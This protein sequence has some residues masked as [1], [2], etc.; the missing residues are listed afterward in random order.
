MFI[1]ETHSTNDL[2]KKMSTTE[3]LEEYYT[4]R[5]DYQSAGKGQQGAKWESEKGKNLLVSIL[6]YPNELEKK[7]P[8]RLTQ[9][10]TVATIQALRVV[11]PEQTCS[12]KWPNDIYCG[13]K[14]LAGILIENVLSEDGIEKSVLGM[15]LNVNQVVFSE[16][17]PNPIS[18][19]LLNPKTYDID[20][21]LNNIVAELK[22]I[23]QMDEVELKSIYLSHLYRRDG[24]HPYVE[25]PVTAG[26]MTIAKT[27]M[28]GAFNA[29]I[30]DIKLDGEIEL[31]KENNER[32]IYHF[33][34]IK[35]IIL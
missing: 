15:G 6:L 1:S 22:K 2:L 12:I 35:Y 3:R 19:Q 33:K 8:F 17:L 29:K 26:P 7:H 16:A 28:E 24:F 5:T 27:N 23:R 13:D 25:I 31:E 4:I 14:K 20:N 11:E 18:L 30:V 34:Q 21:I 9:L 32:K 10:F